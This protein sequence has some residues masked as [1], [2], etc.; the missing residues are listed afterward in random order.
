MAL[1]VDRLRTGLED[2]RG[3]LELQRHALRSEY[4]ELQ[5]RFHALF[6]VYGGGMAEEFRHR[7]ERTAGWFEAYL[8]KAAAL[9]QF[10]ADR[11]EQLRH[12]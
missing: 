11:I 9:D 4:V 12:L 8:N 2:Y 7:W 5:R 1:D 10:L 3:T 6:A